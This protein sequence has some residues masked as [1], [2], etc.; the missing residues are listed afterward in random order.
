MGTLLDFAKSYSLR[1]RAVESARD[2]QLQAFAPDVAR[3]VRVRSEPARQSVAPT[4]VA[5]IMILAAAIW[6]IHLWSDNV[7]LRIGVPSEYRLEHLG[8]TSLGSDYRSMKDGWTSNVGSKASAIRQAW[9]HWEPN[10]KP[11][12]QEEK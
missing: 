5:I 11:E 10:L 3:A 7:Q 8:Y 4:A 2:E 1:V 12:W 9:K 6:I